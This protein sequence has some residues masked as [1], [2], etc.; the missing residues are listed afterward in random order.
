MREAVARRDPG[1]AERNLRF[2][3]TALLGHGLLGQTGFRLI[4]AP[5]FLP[6][7]VSVLAGHDSAAAVMRAIQSLGQFLSPLPSAS[8]VERR[9]RVKHLALLF[10]GITR[11]QVM[12]YGLIALLVPGEAALLLVWTVAALHGLAMGMQGVA[13]QFVMSK[14]IPVERRGLLMGLRNAAAMASLVVVAL[15]GGWLVERHGFPNGYG[16]TFLLGFALACLGLGAFGLVREP[17]SLEPRGHTPLRARLREVPALLR[18]EPDFGRYLAALLTGTAA[19]GVLPLYIG[20]VAQRFG[21]TGTRLGA[22]TTVFVVCQGGSGLVWGP[23]GD[24]IGYRAIFGA[25]LGCW[26][27]G[28]AMLL[29]APRFELT[30]AVYGLVGAG[31]GGFMLASRNLVLEFGGERDRPLRIALGNSLSELS[32]ALGFAAAGVTSWLVSLEAAFAGSLALQG[33]ALV[34]VRRVRD[35]RHASRGTD[36]GF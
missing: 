18:A 29:L 22:L 8:L 21:V 19:R 1:G 31:T 15:V 20:L 6:H 36:D 3:F 10:G 32:G 11:I 5:T 14:A 34:M 30:F 7:F 28:T 23:L 9:R 16:Y 27:L 24:R 35:P 26:A 2:N 4:Q 12:G 17:D 13:F 25:A 33:I